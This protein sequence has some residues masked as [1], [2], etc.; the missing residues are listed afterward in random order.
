MIKVN[1]GQIEINGN[2]IML[3]SELAGL[4][5]GMM[6][7]GIMTADVIR[8]SLAYAEHSSPAR[9]ADLAIKLLEAATKDEDDEEDSAESFE[10]FGDMM[11]MLFHGRRVKE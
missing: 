11:D 4:F 7:E 10:G 3:A 5:K 1:K 2:R 6:E 9:S 8:A